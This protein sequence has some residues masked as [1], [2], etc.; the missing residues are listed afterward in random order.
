MSKNLKHYQALDKLVTNALLA[1]Y[2]TISQQGGFW[3]TKRRNELL[4]KF[5]KPKVKEAQYS[6]C[7]NE[8]KIMLNIG[9]KFR[10]NLEKKL[11]DINVIN[12]AYQE[13]FSHV[14]DLYIMLSGVFE[15]YQFNFIRENLSKSLEVDTL[16]MTRDEIKSG[17]DKD[18]RQIKPLAMKIRTQR[19]DVLI[20]AIQAKGVYRVE[21]ISLVEDSVSHLLLHREKP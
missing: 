2:C 13:K 5:I 14:D 10:G 18:N 12:L 6:M 11:W 4:I 9:R 16:Y 19:L 8:L 17:F 1:L 7:K 3:T 21:V 20:D 15:Q